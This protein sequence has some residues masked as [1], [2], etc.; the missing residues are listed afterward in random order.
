VE[1]L[2]W[3]ERPSLRRPVLVGAFEGWNDAGEAATMALRSL[4]TTWSARRIA[5]VD[6]E[7]FYDFSATRPEVHLVD[8]VTRRIEWPANELWVAAAP[9]HD[10]VLLLGVEPQLRWRTFCTGLLGAASDLGVELVITLGALLADVPHTRA[11]RVTGAAHDPDLAQRLGL[12]RS[13]YEGPTG[14]VGVLHD[15]CAAQGMPSASLWAA[16]PHYVHQV[17]SPKA[18]LAL[19]ERAAVLVGASVDPAPLRD[20]AEEYV[21]QVSEQVEAD[22]DAA[23]Y[24]ARLEAADDAEQEAER[25][26]PSADALAAEV[27]RFLR[28]HRRE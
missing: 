7:E 17:P 24:V 10:I 25:P 13:R 20:A 28:D 5:S 19:V 12:Q 18:A 27:E 3:D 6:P 26:L 21:R 22:E 14:I 15:T 1:F 4:A 9:A 2:R 16:V 8:G 11:V 23:A